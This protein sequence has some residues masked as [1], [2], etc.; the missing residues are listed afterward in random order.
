MVIFFCLPGALFG[1]QM[2]ENNYNGHVI[3][4]LENLFNYS[5]PLSQNTSISA[6][7]KVPLGM[8][9]VMFGSNTGLPQFFTVN[10]KNKSTRTLL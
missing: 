7:Y 4:L 3:I 1:L 9:T 6:P 8:E 10:R 2:L 5:H